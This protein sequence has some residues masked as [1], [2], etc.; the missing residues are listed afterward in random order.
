MGVG[1]GGIEAA[2]QPGFVL[3]EVQEAGAGDINFGDLR[4]RGQ[5]RLQ[6]DGQVARLHRGRFGQHQGDVAGVVAVGSILGGFHLDVRRQAGRQGAVFGQAGEGLLDQLADGV[7]HLCLRHRA[8]VGGRPVVWLR[9]A[10]Y[11]RPEGEA[12]RCKL[13]ATS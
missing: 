13:K 2:G 11:R 9:T 5:R 10:H 8:R 4:V 6:L 3:E 12:A 7:F 1:E